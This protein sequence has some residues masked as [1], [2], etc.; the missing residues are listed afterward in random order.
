MNIDP[1]E[2]SELEATFAAEKAEE[3]A[4]AHKTGWS[5]YDELHWLRG[6]NERSPVKCR[7]LCRMYLDGGRRWDKHID[8]PRI[9]QLCAAIA[10]KDVR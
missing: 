7:E 10:H 1:L 8:V 6:F 4:K 3:E 9:M 5:T 2:L